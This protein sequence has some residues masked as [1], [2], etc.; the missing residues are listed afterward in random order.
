MVWTQRTPRV[1]TSGRFGPPLAVVSRTSPWISSPCS[2]STGTGTNSTSGNAARVVSSDAEPTWCSTRVTDTADSLARVPTAT[3]WRRGRNPCYAIPRYAAANRP[4]E[5][6]GRTSR[7]G[8]PSGD[9]ARPRRRLR[10]RAH[11]RRL[12]ARR[13]RDGHDLPLLLLQGRAAR[14]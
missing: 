2:P 1:R 3:H 9:D 10:G 5:E 11:A 14:G 13:R 12:G 6:A 4:R 7:S 8:D